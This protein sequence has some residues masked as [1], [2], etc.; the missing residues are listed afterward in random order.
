[1]DS[2]RAIK[3]FKTLN[4]SLGTIYTRRRLRCG[5]I[6]ARTGALW[7]ENQPGADS[8]QPQALQLGISATMAV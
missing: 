2:D 1:M 7:F 4:M 6:V 8:W 3:T 5:R